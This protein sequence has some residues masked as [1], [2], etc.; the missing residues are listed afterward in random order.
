MSYQ[1]F[2]HY[3]SLLSEVFC[4]DE[5]PESKQ[6]G[7]KNSTGR[8]TIIGR[9][10]REREEEKKATKRQAVKYKCILSRLCIDE[11]NDVMFIKDAEHF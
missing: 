9:N 7:E 10:I 6:N 5:T 4:E 2:R 1:T 8:K 11:C 3:C